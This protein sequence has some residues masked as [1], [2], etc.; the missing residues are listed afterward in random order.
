[1]YFGAGVARPLARTAG[2]RSIVT[3]ATIAAASSATT[4]VQAEADVA[5]NRMAAE[6]LEARSLND[7]EQRAGVDRHPFADVDLGDRAVAAGAQLVLHL[8]RFDD[9]DRLTGA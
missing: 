2:P 6:A 9:H 8:H 4:I 1:M 3:D 7:D 5:E